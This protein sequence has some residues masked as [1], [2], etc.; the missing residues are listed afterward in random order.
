MGTDIQMF[1]ECRDLDKWHLAS[2]MFQNPSYSPTDALSYPPSFPKTVYDERNYDLYDLLTGRFRAHLIE[3]FG[4]SIGVRGLPVDV[5][6]E[7]REWYDFFGVY[8][9][10][11]SWLLLSEV[12]AFPWEKPTVNHITGRETT[13]ARIAGP[14]F[15]EGVIGLRDQYKDPSL[16]RLVF[17]FLA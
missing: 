13:F 6:P 17:W 3:G 11:A 7:I 2:P 15:M 1:V 5:S 10:H 9:E 14:A 12:L 8:A 16:V 4:A